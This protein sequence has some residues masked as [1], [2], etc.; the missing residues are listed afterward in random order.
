M[1]MLATIMSVGQYIGMALVL[2]GLCTFLAPQLLPARGA[3]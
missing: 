3:K 2:V 1:E